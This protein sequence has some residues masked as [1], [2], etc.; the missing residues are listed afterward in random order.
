M[1]NVSSQDN[2]EES[3]P[4]KADAIQAKICEKCQTD[5]S[6]NRKNRKAPLIQPTECCPGSEALGNDGKQWVI[7]VTNGKNKWVRKN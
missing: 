7:K 2:E 5:S 4:I 6:L 3:Q 1:G